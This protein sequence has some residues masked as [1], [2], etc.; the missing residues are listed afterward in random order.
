MNI[1]THMNFTSISACKTMSVPR[2]GTHAVN[3]SAHA[4]TH[5]PIRLEN[6]HY[7]QKPVQFVINKN[8]SRNPNDWTYANGIY[9]LESLYEWYRSGHM[10][11]PLTRLPLVWD[12]YDD[13][14]WDV[15]P[16]NLP[17]NYVQRTQERLE[18]LRSQGPSEELGTP[19][20]VGRIMY[21]FNG[22]VMCLLASL[23]D[24]V[25]IQ[26]PIG[27]RQLQRRSGL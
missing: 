8:D 22:I 24:A 14:E 26:M 25:I 4:N 17:W 12:N 21:P 15:R 20:R 16:A 18:E 1:Y 9:D 6:V 5:D 13:V 23:A 3:L 19:C 27:G 2:T 11:D 7:I 10:T